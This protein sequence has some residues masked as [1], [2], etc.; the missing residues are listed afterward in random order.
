MQNE[1]RKDQGKGNQDELNRQGGEVR[2]SRRDRVPNN[3]YA[4]G[5]EEL[6]RVP[7]MMI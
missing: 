1:I 3:K 5:I 4:D 7:T 2:R 6:R